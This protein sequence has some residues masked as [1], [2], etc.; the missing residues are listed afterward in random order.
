M[1]KHAKPWTQM[2]PSPAEVDRAAV[3]A[4]TTLVE[5]LIRDTEFYTR[6]LPLDASV[7]V[8]V[9]RNGNTAPAVINVY[10]REEFHAMGGVKFFENLAQMMAQ[11]VVEEEQVQCSVEI[12]DGSMFDTWG[13]LRPECRGEFIAQRNPDGWDWR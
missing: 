9:H 5:G 10:R 13:T 8:G 3:A 6:K 7:F 1:L 12:I 4:Y 2:P 11:E